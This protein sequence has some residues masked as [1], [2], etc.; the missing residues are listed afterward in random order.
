MHIEPRQQ[1]ALDARRELLAHRDEIGRGDIEDVA[2]EELVGGDVDHFERHGEAAAFVEEMA[3]DDVRGVERL[4]RV[5][6]V[7]VAAD[8]PR[9]GE[10]AHGQIVAVAEDRGDLVGDGQA[11]VVAGMVDAEGGEGED[12]DG[13]GAF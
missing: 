5:A 13:F 8:A 12:G 9:D 7:D 6:R 4:R 3:A 1:A 11:E 10:G 2:P